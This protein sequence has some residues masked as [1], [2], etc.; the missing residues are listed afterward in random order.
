[1]AHIRTFKTGNCTAT[2]IIN[3]GASALA[4]VPQVI[5]ARYLLNGIE[6][7]PVFEFGFISI[8]LGTIGLILMF[9]VING[10]I[11]FRIWRKTTTV[12][13]SLSQQNK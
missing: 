10:L 11:R 13:D 1:L 2:I 6:Q 3:N 9:V 5:Y 4:N 12:D 8:V 7:T